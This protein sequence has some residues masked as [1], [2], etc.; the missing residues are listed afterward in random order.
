MNTTEETVS[1]TTFFKKEK[2]KVLFD[3]RNDERRST[4]RNVV[5]MPVP[6]Q[7]KESI[8][9]IKPRRQTIKRSYR[10][11]LKIRKALQDQNSGDR[12]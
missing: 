1:R 10:L 2:C 4:V 5:K 3:D 11:K 7:I 8:I 12:N 6:F 9:S